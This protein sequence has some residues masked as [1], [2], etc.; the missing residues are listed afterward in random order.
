VERGS[1]KIRRTGSSPLSQRDD[2][3]REER[4]GLPGEL[5]LGADWP[6]REQT[7]AGDEPPGEG[8]QPQ[9]A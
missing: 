8:E 4:S 9:Q 1:T 6:A 7:L 3:E 5:L 2:A